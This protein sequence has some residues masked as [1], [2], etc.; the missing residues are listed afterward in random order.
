MLERMPL[1]LDGNPRF[2]N[3]RNTPDTGCGPGAT[4][5]VG[6]HEFQGGI[7]VEAILGDIDGDEIVG[8]ID[9]LALLAA[10]G[11]C[12]EECCLADLDS[13]TFVGIAD[14]L[15]LLSNWSEG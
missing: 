7:A 11:P 6:A 8:I 14:F 1:D 2:V 12:A 13:N 9:F 10:W 4:V 3:D 15:L 5:D